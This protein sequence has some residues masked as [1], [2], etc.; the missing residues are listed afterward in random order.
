MFWTVVLEKTWESL[1]LQGDQSSQSWIIIGRTDTE[2]SVLWP[3]DG[4][5]WLIGEDPDA[6][7]DWRQE[8]KGTAEDEM[9]GWHHWLEDMSLS[10]FRELV[11]DKEDWC[12][13]VPGVAKSWT[14][15]SD[16]TELNSRWN[17]SKVRQEHFEVWSSWASIIEKWRIL[18]GLWTHGATELN[19][20]H[21]HFIWAI[22]AWL[23]SPGTEIFFFSFT[24]EYDCCCWVTSVVSDS[25]R[26]HR[27]QPTRLPRPWDSPG[28]NTGVG[29]HFLLQCVKVKSLSRV[30]ILVTPRTSAYQAPPSMGFSR[31]EYWNGVPLPSLRIWLLYGINWYFKAF[32]FIHFQ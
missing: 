11:M 1:G 20:S 10:K 29:C 2:A 31:Q 6:G 19:W 7:K 30:Q 5:N 3:L 9:V 14:R 24:L 28:K 18:N 32:V 16:W 4:K 15:L 26:P 22:K 12:A 13:A 21:C 8:E 25:V 23:W 17:L 27:R